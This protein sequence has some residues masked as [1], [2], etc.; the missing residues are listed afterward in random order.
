MRFIREKPKCLSCAAF[1]IS[2]N[3]YYLGEEKK[4]LT[5][6]DQQTIAATCLYLYRIWTGEGRVWF[7][8]G[9]EGGLSG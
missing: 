9:D 2:F 5:S 4:S 7:W 8:N 1:K 3:S 6:Y